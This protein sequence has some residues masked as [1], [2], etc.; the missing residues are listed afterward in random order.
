MSTS[1]PILLLKRC[2]QRRWVKYLLVGGINTL[3]GYGVYALLLWA[4]LH[5]TLATLF[6]TA[7][8]IIFNFKTYGIIVFKNKSN[9]LIFRY[10]VVYGVLYAASNGW[11]FLLEQLGVTPYI[12][13]MIWLAPNALLG[14]LMSKK[15]VYG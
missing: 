6:S 14:F 2:V 1:L 10:A 4:G 15:F 12:S 8:G 5:Y 11:I 9:A 3:F 13:G 7:L